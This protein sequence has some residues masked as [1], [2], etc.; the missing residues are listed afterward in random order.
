MPH[1][2]DYGGH[3]NYLF[4]QLLPGFRIDVGQKAFGCF[5]DQGQLKY[6]LN[7]AESSWQN[8]DLYDAVL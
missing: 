4:S 1:Q 2:I 5:W 6:N 7:T 3:R 8:Q